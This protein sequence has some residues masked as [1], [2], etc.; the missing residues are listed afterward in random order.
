L[1]DHLRQA[2]PLI[3][4]S[5][6]VQSGKGDAARWL[7]KFNAAYALKI[8]QLVFPGSL[9]V[10]LAEPFDWFS[11]E[12]AART[13]QFHR[14]DYGGERDILLMPC[15]L[16]SLGNERA[17]LWTPTTAAHD[18]PDPWVIEMIAGRNLREAFALA[19]GDAVTLELLD[20]PHGT[21]R[22]A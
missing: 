12:N 10:A 5:G 19:D 1:R 9:N 18:R 21:E 6:R 13:I 20:R 16:R 15:V 3:L 4:L 22:L 11:E 14:T 2:N 7:S 8:G 17:W